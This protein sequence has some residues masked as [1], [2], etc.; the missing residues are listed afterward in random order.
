MGSNGYNVRFRSNDFQFPQVKGVFKKLMSTNGLESRLFA[1]SVSGMRPG[2][3]ETRRGFIWWLP[4][5]A[6]L[7][8]PPS[9]SRSV[10]M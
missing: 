9:S 10:G 3:R 1:R 2:E 7:S 6:N 4:Y 5:Y 8:R